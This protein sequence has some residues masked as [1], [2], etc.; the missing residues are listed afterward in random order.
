MGVLSCAD[1]RQRQQE[2]VRTPADRELHSRSSSSLVHIEGKVRTH[3]RHRLSSGQQRQLRVRKQRHSA[4]HTKRDFVCCV[5]LRIDVEI[6]VQLSEL[7]FTDVFPST[8]L[9]KLS[10]ADDDAEPEIEHPHLF[11]NPI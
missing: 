11:R 9:V 6:S 10:D 5:C 7:H 8:P 2:E 3:N 4:S 1:P